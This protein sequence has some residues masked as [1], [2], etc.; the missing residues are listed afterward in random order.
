VRLVKDERARLHGGERVGVPVEDV[1]VEDDDLGG[2]RLVGP[3]RVGAPVQHGHAPVREPVLGLA[4]PD[5]LHARRAHDHG[6]KCPVGLERGQSLHG[7]AEALL[8][9]DEG[10][11]AREGVAHARTLEG[12]QLPAEREILELGVLGVRERHGLGRALVLSHQ[13]VDQLLRGLLHE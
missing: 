6:G 10:A 3:G 1:V 13:L 4:L 11:P 8:V 9:G 12:V 7:L 2:A 5:E